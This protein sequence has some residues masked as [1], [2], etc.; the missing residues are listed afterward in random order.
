MSELNKTSWWSRQ[1]GELMFHRSWL[2][3]PL[4]CPLC[5]P[6]FLTFGDLSE[7]ALCPGNSLLPVSCCLVRLGGLNVN[8]D[9]TLQPLL[10]LSTDLVYSWICISDRSWTGCND[11]PGEKVPQTPV[12]PLSH[13]FV[14]KTQHVVK[15][16]W[17]KELIPAAVWVVWEETP[18]KPN[19][20]EVT[21]QNEA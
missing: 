20:R 16:R 9:T 19:F 21:E 2:L 3:P 7:N 5:A 10:C 12:G 6:S 1:G 17:W 15:T 18:D 14:Q 4:L 13:L 11:R 8:H